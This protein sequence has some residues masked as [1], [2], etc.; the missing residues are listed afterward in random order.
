MIPRALSQV[1]LSD[2]LA[3]LVLPDGTQSGDIAEEQ[4]HA[5]KEFQ[6]DV[7]LDRLLDVFLS[8]LICFDEGL[9]LRKEVSSNRVFVL[10]DLSTLLLDVRH[11]V[12]L[13]FKAN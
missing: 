10:V 3:A 12:F 6:R 5:E 9:L 13:I 4:R 7:S 2:C 1:V 8:V 11:D